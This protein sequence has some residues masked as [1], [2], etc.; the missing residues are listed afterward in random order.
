MLSTIDVIPVQPQQILSELGL[1]AD[2]VGLRLIKERQII[3]EVRD[4]QPRSPAAHT[5]YGA[6][7]EV[8]A[9]GQLGYAATPIVNKQGLQSAA[10][11]A[12]GQAIAASQWSIFPF[13]RAVRPTETG[14]YL[15]KPEIDLEQVPPADILARLDELGRSLRVSDQIVQTT[16]L[17]IATQRECWLIDQEQAADIYQNQ[18]WVT[19]HLSATAK[20]GQI[21]QTRTNHGY[22]AHTYQ[23]GWE[24]LLQPELLEHAEQIG[25]E[26][27]ELLTAAECPD[28]TT[29]LVL[30]PDQMMLQLHESVGHP[31]EL[32]RI[33]GDERNY[34][35]GSFVSPQDFGQLQYGSPLMNVTFDPSLPFELASYG[36]DD[37]GNPAQRHYL[38]Q[39]GQLQRGL[40]SLESQSRLGVQGVACARMSSWNRPPI[41][42]MANLNLEPGQEG[43][44]SMIQQIEH[45]VLMRS[46][47]SWSI[48][49]RRY[50]F[51]FGCEYAQLIE[52]GQITKTLRNPNYRGVTPAFWH[53]LIHVGDRSTWQAFGTPMCGKG[54]P[55]QMVGVGH[56]APVCAFANVEVFGGGEA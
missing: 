55:Q 56:G 14:H 35:G 2:W 13:T 48:D 54:E 34:A 39:D 31:L 40:G 9:Q 8:L 26:A 29:T 16:A 6:M 46:N 21:V 19:A 22:H 44:D 4:G 12:Y 53:N 28:R 5:S 15:A 18:S 47:R 30:A 43:L 17:A 51:Q 50:K 24:V 37:T 11:R 3:Y 23:G 45:G 20:D 10:R 7:V 36:Y 38:I 33:L 1:Q 27:V 41:D 49:D 25:R 42:R 32:D 52:N